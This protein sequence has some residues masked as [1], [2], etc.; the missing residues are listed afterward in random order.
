MPVL[1][2]P[3]S[4]SE[5]DSADPRSPRKLLRAALFCSVS[6]YC[7]ACLEEQ[8]AGGGIQGSW[9]LAA[10]GSSDA[11]AGPGTPP[12]TGAASRAGQR[13]RSSRKEP[14]FF[15]RWTKIIIYSNNFYVEAILLLS[16]GRNSY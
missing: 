8:E 3:Q 13:V 7:L 5:E 14:A 11:A 10:R 4:E 16:E 9:R 12:R 15:L 6:P 2:A 1:D